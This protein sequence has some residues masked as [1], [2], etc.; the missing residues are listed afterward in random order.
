VLESVCDP[1]G[2]WQMLCGVEGCVEEGEPR[3]V[4]VGHLMENDQ[5]INELSQLKSGMFAERPSAKSP[6]KFGEL[7]D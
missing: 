7:S 3:Y 2:D 6:W 4:G 5:S 1:D